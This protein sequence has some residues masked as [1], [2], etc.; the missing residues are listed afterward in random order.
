MQVQAAQLVKRFEPHSRREG[1]MK[2]REPIT[3]EELRTHGACRSQR[4]TFNF[5]WPNGCSV[6]LRNAKWAA[7]L[8]L[9]IWFAADHLLSPTLRKEWKKQYF[10]LRRLKWRAPHRYRKVAYN[11][12]GAIA[13]YCVCRGKSREEIVNIVRREYKIVN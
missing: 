5:T 6:T 8:G 13:F 7:A 3:I 1:K 11:R 10:Y 9:D 2:C 4:S 12:L